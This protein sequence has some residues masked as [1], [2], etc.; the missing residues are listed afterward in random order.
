MHE[1]T[2]P[3]THANATSA[4]DGPLSSALSSASITR[5][6]TCPFCP[7][8]C[9]DID[10]HLA[11][12]QTLAAPATRCTRL[13][14]ALTRY[15]A[16][17]NVCS[18]SVDGSPVPLDTALDE[19][20]D[21]LVQA[22][23]S[24]FGGCA[25]DIAGARALYTLA[26]GCGAILD[27]VH[28]DA[29]SAATLALQDRGAFFTTL[30]E[31]RSRAD[32]LVVFACEPSALHP[33]FYERIPSGNSM[34]RE[35]RFVCC[36]TDPA[37]TEAVNTHTAS[38][39]IDTSP[40]DVLALWSAITEGGRNAESLEDG[41]G[42]ATALT[43]LT[44]RIAEARY[45]VF[46][47]E[48]AALPQPHAALLIEA[49]HRIVK[50]INRTNRAGVLTLGGADGALSMNQTV[51]WLSG[52]PLR[53][54]VSKPDRLPGTPPLDYDPYRYRTERLL[55]A[56]EADALLWTASFD[57]HPLPVELAATTPVIV[58]G[59]PALGSAIAAQQTRS[60]KTVFI[61]VATPGIDSDGHL[62]RVDTSVVV[63][64]QAA[65]HVALPSVAS[66][67]T[68]L[69]DKLVAQARRPA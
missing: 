5:D 46:V 9:D 26:A 49:L 48:P 67:A 17:D 44:A 52:F 18:P 38:L 51:T 57:P 28:G 54:R 69:A 62:F 63:P 68:R 15:D 43:A 42:I 41:A 8:L 40:H 24:L 55:A 59:T 29:I 58:L 6:W 66:I 64:L 2:S 32:L 13:A 30:S 65:R 37:A 39:L 19:A 20:V 53:T 50:S 61:P 21:V 11:A 10:A 56:G 4:A 16:S 14:D 60:A 36:D 33:R 47:I 7:L 34:A 25:T 45:T 35:I 31:V 22:R 3:T 27:S 23:R 1:S 12:N